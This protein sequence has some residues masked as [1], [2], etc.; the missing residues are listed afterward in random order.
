MQIYTTTSTMMQPIY[1]FIISVTQQLTMA[2]WQTEW[3]KVDLLCGWSVMSSTLEGE[4]VTLV[5]NNSLN[6]WVSRLT[7]EQFQM[8]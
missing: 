7:G 3:Y 8:K 1:L 4:M 5:L 2:N 6:S